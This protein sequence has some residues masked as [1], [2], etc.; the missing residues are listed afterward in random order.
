MLLNWRAKHITLIL[1]KN[2]RKIL[3]IKDGSTQRERIAI[4]ILKELGF[5]SVQAF[6][7]AE[8]ITDDG[9]IGPNTYAR[10]YNRYLKVKEFPFRGSFFEQAFEK[11]QI[12]LHHSAGWDNAR[13]MFQSWIN[14]GVTHVA[15]AIGITDDGVVT[16]GYDEQFWAYHIGLSMPILEQQSVAVEI[17][18]WGALQERGGKFFTWVNDYGRRGQAVELPADKVIELNYKGIAYYEKYTAAEIETTRRWI[19]LNAMRF[20]IPIEYSHDDIWKVSRKAI[21]GQAGLFSH[22][23]FIEWKSDI[24]PQ[25]AMIEMLQ[26]LND[27]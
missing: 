26:G 6:Q 3:V 11:K 22:N 2:M 23:S 4:Q 5:N 19:L 13:G 17:C 8:G 16:R 21:A 10:I 27:L 20:D 25:P 9:I 15:T 24:S 18:N 14:D 1:F 7:R 12:V